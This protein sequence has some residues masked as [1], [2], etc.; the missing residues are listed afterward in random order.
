MSAT[1]LAVSDDQTLHNALRNLLNRDPDFQLVGE[2]ENGEQAVRSMS[3]FHP[4]VVLMDISGPDANGFEAT[5]KIKSCRPY[6]K[7]ILLSVQSANK[8]EDTV[9]G[10]GPDAFIAKRGLDSEL[11]PTIRHVLGLTSNHPRRETEDAVSV[12]LV[13]DDVG[14]L[15]FAADYL[16]ARRGI[17]VTGCSWSGKEAIPKISELKPD[18]AVVDLELPDVPGLEIIS[19]LRR[20]LPGLAIIAFSSLNLKRYSKRVFAAGADKF[21]PKSG[22]ITDLVPAILTLARHRS[23]DDVAL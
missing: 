13:D 20:A 17:T 3:E 1:I 5:R 10:I 23:T 9:W 8:D 15:T 14:F 19:A 4:D 12:F 22:L 21:I 16:R 2:A 7:V 6:T 18:V 11:L